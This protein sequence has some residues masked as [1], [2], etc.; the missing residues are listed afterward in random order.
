MPE[1]NNHS[2]DGIIKGSWPDGLPTLGVNRI[3]WKQ[4]ERD[5]E[6]YRTQWDDFANLYAPEKAMAVYDFTRFML[7]Q[8]HELRTLH[9]E[10][11]L[12]PPKK[13]SK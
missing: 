4:V 3:N 12:Q 9:Y 7:A 13:E 5:L 2:V 1:K 6:T 10:F 8:L 11:K